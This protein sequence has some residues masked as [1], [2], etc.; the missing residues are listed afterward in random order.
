[1]KNTTTSLGTNKAVLRY[2][3]YDADD[4]LRVR[5]EFHEKYSRMKGNFHEWVIG[6]LPIQPADHLLDVGTGPGDFP[7]LLRRLGHQGVV[8]GMDLSEGMIRTAQDN[9]LARTWVVADAQ[10]LPFAD[11][12]FNGTM[13]RHMLYHV[14]D[15]DRAVQEMAR[16]TVMGGWGAAVTNGRDNM[17]MIYNIWETVQHPAVVHS[18]PISA[19]FP[20][21]GATDYFTPH[22]ADV[23][24]IVQEDVVTLPSV[25]PLVYYLFSGRHLLM[26][27]DHTDAEW[28]EVQAKLVEGAEAV[29]NREAIN[30][31]L[32]ISKRV[33]VIL[34]YRR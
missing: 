26:K 14:P 13:A 16:V 30:G 7:R 25:E 8:V 10:Q 34:G 5:R 24:T 31:L 4:D 2:A 22:F 29:W 12:T 11:G 6:L 15:I 18:D 1:M 21:E 20:L 23:E 33:G 19:R 28:R 9:D 32:T 3:A 17:S 27:S